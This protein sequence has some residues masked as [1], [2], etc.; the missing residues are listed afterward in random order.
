MSSY[1]TKSMVPN[2]K[3]LISQKKKEK[4]KNSYIIEETSK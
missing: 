2:P 1:G 4:K 3:N